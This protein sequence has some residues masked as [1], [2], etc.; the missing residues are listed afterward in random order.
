MDPLALLVNWSRRK[1]SQETPNLL[2]CTWCYFD[3]NRVTGY[4]ILIDL[5]NDNAEKSGRA[6]HVW[7]K[8]G[9]RYNLWDEVWVSDS[10]CHLVVRKLKKVVDIG[11]LARC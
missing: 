11:L 7:W 5:I 1:N 2:Q 4:A 9:S 6:N 8:T 10:D 3:P